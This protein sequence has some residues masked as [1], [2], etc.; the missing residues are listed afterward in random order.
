ML[1]ILV[2][3]LLLTVSLLCCGQESG[4]R[5]IILSDG[6][7]QQILSEGIQAGAEGYRSSA[8]IM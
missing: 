5:L 7:E 1:N 3:D 6:Q 2:Y 8:R 4:H